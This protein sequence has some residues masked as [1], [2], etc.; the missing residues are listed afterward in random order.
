MPLTVHIRHDSADS[1]RAHKA[2]GANLSR[3]PNI[4]DPPPIEFVITTLKREVR[5]NNHFIPP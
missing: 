1:Y 5:L 4:V 2:D 3:R